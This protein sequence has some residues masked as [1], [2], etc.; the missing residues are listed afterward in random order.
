MWSMPF[1]FIILI[2]F[3]SIELEL[4]QDNTSFVTNE[5]LLQKILI[6]GPRVKEVPKWTNILG[7]CCNSGEVKGR[8]NGCRNYPKHVQKRP[9]LSHFYLLKKTVLGQV[10]RDE[11]LF[12][13]ISGWTWAW[14]G[15]GCGIGCGQRAKGMCRGGLSW[16]RAR[17]RVYCIALR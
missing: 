14:S 3:I 5:R 13:L 11:P 8:N 17:C 16:L 15:T 4:M 12:G 6:I 9:F 7:S 2:P 1:C 10:G